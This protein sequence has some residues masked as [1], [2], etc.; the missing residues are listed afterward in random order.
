MDNLI[1]LIKFSREKRGW[2]QELLAERVNVSKQWLSRIESGA[3]APSLKLLVDL[4]EELIQ[5][6]GD[7]PEAHFEIWLLR[8]IEQKAQFEDDLGESGREHIFKA[9]ENS[10]EYVP[11]THPPPSVPTPLPSSRTSSMAPDFCGVEP[12]VRTTVASTQG[13]PFSR[14][15]TASWITSFICYLHCYECTVYYPPV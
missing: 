7:E 3:R 5:G 14:S 8:W 13:S 1:E 15:S 12:L 6:D 9:V 2:T 4:F 10:I 11:S